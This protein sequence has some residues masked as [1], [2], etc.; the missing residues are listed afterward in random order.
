[1]SDTSTLPDEFADLG[2]PGK[3]QPKNRKPKGDAVPVE[4]GNTW[5][6]KPV[7]YLIGGRRQEFFLIGH[8]A[9]ALGYSVQSIRAWEAAHLLPRTPFR[10]PRASGMMAGGK[11]DKGKRLWTRRQI[12]D[13]L[14]VARIHN[15]IVNREAPTPGFAADV[16]P[17]F[18]TERENVLSGGDGE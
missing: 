8:L 9:R 1:M 18:V 11:S 14:E 6:A 5:D 3:R 7:F 4:E 13:I 10:S 12:E 15:V 16:T 2:Y 17:R